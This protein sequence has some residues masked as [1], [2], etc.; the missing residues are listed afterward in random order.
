VLEMEI[1]VTQN[2]VKIN[3]DILNDGEY[4]IHKCQFDFDGE[5][6]G[7]VQKAVFTLNEGTSYLET[8]VNNECNWV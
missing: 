4:N 3:K 1:K 7:L 8:I 5:Y 2:E 6:N